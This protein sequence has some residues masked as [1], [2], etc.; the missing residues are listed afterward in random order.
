MS[1]HITRVVNVVLFLFSVVF[2]VG[3]IA[4]VKIG[5]KAVKVVMH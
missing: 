1:S 4:I 3:E 5:E 2:I